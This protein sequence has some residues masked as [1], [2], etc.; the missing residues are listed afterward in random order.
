MSR[1]NTR[2]TGD[3][4]AQRTP[5]RV[6]VEQKPRISKTRSALRR[7]LR[8]RPQVSAKRPPSHALR[9]LILSEWPLKRIGLRKAADLKGEI[10]ATGWLNRTAP[11][12]EIVSTRHAESVRH[13]GNVRGSVYRGEDP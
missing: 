6:G 11:G 13:N 8:Q 2:D 12:V 5:Q 9:D 1:Q 4:P 3:D 7:W 10:R